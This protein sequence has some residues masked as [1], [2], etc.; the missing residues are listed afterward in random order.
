MQA[1]QQHLTRPNATLHTLALRLCELEP[2][3]INTLLPALTSGS[4][5]QLFVDHNQNLNTFAQQLSIHGMAEQVPHRNQLTSHELSRDQ[6]YAFYHATIDTVLTTISMRDTGLN[7][8]SAMALCRLAQAL[9]AEINSDLSANP[10]S[11]QR[12]INCQYQYATAHTASA[13]HNTNN[14]VTATIYPIRRNRPAFF[15]AANASNTVNNNPN[16]DFSL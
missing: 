9:H 14:Q 15:T 13:Q 7:P 12:A 8:E 16:R 10:V 11:I 2:A 1:I 4:L 3:V 6:N 5:R